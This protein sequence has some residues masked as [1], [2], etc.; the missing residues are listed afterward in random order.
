MSTDHSTANGAYAPGGALAGPARAWTK[1]GIMACPTSRL[2]RNLRAH[3]TTLGLACTSSMRRNDFIATLLDYAKTAPQFIK[4]EKVFCKSKQHKRTIEV[5]IDSV[6][7]DAD[8]QDHTYGVSWIATHLPTAKALGQVPEGDLLETENH[9][10][11]PQVS[12]NFPR[13]TVVS[14]KLCADD[15]QPAAG[16]AAGNSI[17]GP[18]RGTVLAT[19]DLNSNTPAYKACADAFLSMHPEFGNFGDFLDLSAAAVVLVRWEPWLSQTFEFVLEADLVVQQGVSDYQ[20]AAASLKSDDYPAVVRGDDDWMR[21]PRGSYVRIWRIGRADAPVP[22]ARWD[23][24]DGDRAQIVAA[25]TEAGRSYVDVRMLTGNRGGQILSVPA[26]R[27]QPVHFEFTPGM[28]VTFN[29]DCWSDTTTYNPVATVVRGQREADGAVSIRYGA[30]DEMLVKPEQLTLIPTFPGCSEPQN[31]SDPTDGYITY[32]GITGGICAGKT[33]AAEKLVRSLTECGIT[34][35]KVDEAASTVIATRPELVERM[36]SDDCT[37][38]DRVALQTAILRQ[39]AVAEAE[40]TL[41]AQAAARDR[42]VVVVCDRTMVDGATFCS[43][44][45]WQ[46]LLQSNADLFPGIDLTKDI[47]EVNRLIMQRHYDCVFVLQSTAVGAVAHYESGSDSNNPC[48]FSAS[49]SSLA[50][51]LPSKGTTPFAHPR[52][53]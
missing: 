22:G 4:G 52:T 33:K 46:E 30:D 2:V 24:W 7:A 41:L 36:Q 43:D 25:S 35:F 40:V 14:L 44:K 29:M 9:Q 28:M 11:G 23:G 42:R 27:V 47:S 17:D 53:A 26:D 18:R 48:R 8:G 39:T 32:I 16:A 34:A 3:C 37:D 5:V 19:S 49:L 45:E 50:S 51:T 6:N 21:L 12:V 38:A 15:G 1:D 10:F 20:Q 13:G 31:L